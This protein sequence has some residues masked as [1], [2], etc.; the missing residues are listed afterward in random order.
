MLIILYLILEI[1]EYW[2][3]PY[4]CELH[5]INQMVATRNKITVVDDIVL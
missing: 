1:E 2:K 3:I 4:G 5:K